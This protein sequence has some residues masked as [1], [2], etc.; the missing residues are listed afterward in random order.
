MELARA[1]VHEPAVLLMD[2]ATVGLDPA[3]RESLVSYVLD[4]CGQRGLSVLWATHL[5]DEAERAHRVVV[6]H[7]GHKLAEGTPAALI[8]QTGQPSL[9]DAFL[10]MTGLSGEKN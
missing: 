7:Q 9:A 4:L 8:D 2:E 10:S 5:V 3:S 1:L 6:L